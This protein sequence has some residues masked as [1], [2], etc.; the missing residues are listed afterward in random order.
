MN[1]SY[2]KSESIFEFIVLIIQYADD[3][4]VEQLL[5]NCFLDADKQNKLPQ[6][7][8]SINFNKE[9]LLYNLI[10]LNYILQS[11]LQY[12]KGESINVNDLLTETDNM[13]LFKHLLALNG[14]C[15]SFDPQ[16]I[17]ENF[18]E[19]FHI[20]VENYTKYKFYY[21][22]FGT[23]FSKTEIFQNGEIYITRYSISY[24]GKNTTILTNEE[25]RS[26]ITLKMHLKNYYIISKTG[27]LYVLTQTLCYFK[28]INNLINEELSIEKN[29]PEYCVWCNPPEILN[30]KKKCINCRNL[31]DLLKEMKNI[32]TVDAV[33]TLN[34]SAELRKIQ[35][36]NIAKLRQKRK[37]YI[38]DV[39]KKA[40]LNKK[41]HKEFLKKLK[42]A[43]NKS[44][45]G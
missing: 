41:L 33:K 30:A 25:D 7:Q 3:K 35:S 34:F 29:K 12:H 26:T 14:C 40:H 18:K 23:I 4:D 15:Y 24:K 31:A 38:E 6:E 13:L 19:I 27:S 17:K 37:K 1:P 22:F 2:L 36:N 43:I 20:L 11:Y 10:G 42:Y 16:L 9:V 44:F 8:L 39:V 45:K 21:E 28:K 32:T 5:K